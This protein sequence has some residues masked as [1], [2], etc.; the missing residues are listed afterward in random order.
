MIDHK[1]LMSKLHD[2]SIQEFLLK[3]FAS[4]LT[5]RQ[6]R[7]KLANVTS[8]WSHC[9]AGVP[10]GTLLGPFSFI[11]FINDLRADI[12]M[13]KYVDDT[14]LWEI[15]SITG[16]D[17]KLQSAANEVLRWSSENNM[18]LNT[19]KTKT[20]VITFSK[21]EARFDPINI[22]GNVIE[23]VDHFK[24]LGLHINDKLT[25]D[26]HV[27]FICKKASQRL[28]FITLLKR[29]GVLESDLITIYCSIVRS[30][31][32]YVAVIWHPGLTK[33]QSKMVEHVQKRAMRIIYPD[34]HY[35]NALV[36]ANIK[37]LSVRRDEMCQNFFKELQCKDHPLHHI[38]PTKRPDMNLR[39]QRPYKIPKMRTLR[40]KKSPI[41]HGLFNYQ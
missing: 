31:M 33:D 8:S 24:L 29:A 25:W 28:Y 32:E 30:I 17:S 20:M 11:L 37:R 40:L 4:F 23:N 9:K 1:I 21:S 15:C 34:S 6:Q 27:T 13:A 41:F 18:A 36:Q 16:N 35:D 22:R 39:Y 5:N 3:W 7:V 38:L 19:E 12:P 26:N 2:I 14:S 10:Q